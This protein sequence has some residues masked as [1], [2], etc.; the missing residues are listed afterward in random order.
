M[1][2]NGDVM[3]SLVHLKGTIELHPHFVAVGLHPLNKMKPKKKYLPY[4][5]GTQCISF[6]TTKI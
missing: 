1:E 5:H 2:A 3:N 6:P 4:F